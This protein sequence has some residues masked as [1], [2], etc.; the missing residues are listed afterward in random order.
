MRFVDKPYIPDLQLHIGTF[1]LE[2]A[3][4]MEKEVFPILGIHH[5]ELYA[6]SAEQLAKDL[7]LFGFQRLGHNNASWFDS[8][9]TSIL[10]G[11][12]DI[13]IV[14][15]EARIPESPVNEFVSKHGNGVK[16]IALRVPDA[17]RAYWVALKRGAI[18]VSRPITIVDPY[19]H[20]TISKIA[21]YGDVV[22]S[23]VE[24]QDYHGAFLPGFVQL[25]APRISKKSGSLALI[26]SLAM[27]MTW[28]AGQI[29][30]R[31]CW[32]S[33]DW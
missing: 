21:T 15:S 19:G 7:S 27:C 4:K 30:M 6:K 11:Q 5:L 31:Q 33:N 12:G 16:D 20:V 24:S 10:L 9:E 8:A 17:T 14:I 23:F 22:H 13:R 1:T 18:P 26:T 2:K 28:N 3:V 29:T 25:N 32:D